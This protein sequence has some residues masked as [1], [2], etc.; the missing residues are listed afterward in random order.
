[1]LLL[2]ETMNFLLPALVRKGPSIKYVTLFF[3]ILTPCHTLSHTPK[4]PPE[5]T[6]HISNTPPPIFSMPSTKNPNKSPCTNSL[7]II[8]AG[9]VRG[10]C[11]RFFC[12]EGFVRGGFCPFPLLSEYICY[13]RK[14]NITQNF[15]FHMYDKNIYKC[16]VTCSFPFPLS[17][18]VTPSRTP[19]PRA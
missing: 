19:S 15:M 11:Q 2:L 7:S 17:Q 5:S 8:R 9:F 18:T 1:M 12:L 3:P 6:S 16:D 10:F 13:N 4:P 14:L